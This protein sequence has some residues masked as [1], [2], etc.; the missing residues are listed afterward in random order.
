[1]SAAYQPGASAC[2]PSPQS[3]PPGAW[4]RSTSSSQPQPGALSLPAPSWGPWGTSHLP[5]TQRAPLELASLLAGNL[6]PGAATE[7][8]SDPPVISLLPT[9]LTSVGEVP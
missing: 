1:M 4:P 6:C 5:G 8:V 3:R 7:G 2:T 9:T